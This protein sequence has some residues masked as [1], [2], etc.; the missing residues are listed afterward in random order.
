M[1]DINYSHSAALFVFSNNT[2][3]LVLQV[4]SQQAK[5]GSD[6]AGL[7]YAQSFKC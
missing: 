4:T 7:K 1:Y 6:S 2:T 3:L 5:V